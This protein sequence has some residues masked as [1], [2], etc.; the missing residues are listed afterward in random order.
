[1]SEE[2]TRTKLVADEYAGLVTV[3]AV[4]LAVEYAGGA[5][6]IW[7]IFVGV[8][9]FFIGWKYRQEA[10]E[11]MDRLYTFLTGCL[12]ALG[13]VG[14]L[15]GVVG[16]CIQVFVYGLTKSLRSPYWVD[17]LRCIVFLVAAFSF[18]RWT[19]EKGQTP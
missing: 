7:D 11:K 19:N 5:Y 3:F 4:L 8:L 10:M 9:C 1:M 16:G 2:K 14:V 17:S 13:I 6:D 18:A 12:L 15:S